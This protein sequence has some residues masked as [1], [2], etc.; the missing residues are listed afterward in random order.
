VRKVL[1]VEGKMLG[2]NFKVEVKETNEN[3]LK[4]ESFVG[5]LTVKL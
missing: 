2:W 1:E 4:V 3:T 5:F